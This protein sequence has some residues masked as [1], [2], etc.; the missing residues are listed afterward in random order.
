LQRPFLHARR[1]ELP[2][3]AGQQPMVFEAQLAADLAVVLASLRA[4]S[5]GA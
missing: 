2:A 4:G 1:I 3:G 5:T